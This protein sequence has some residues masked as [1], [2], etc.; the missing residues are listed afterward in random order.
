M[1]NDWQARGVVIIIIAFYAKTRK[2]VLPG[3]P[4]DDIKEA[5]IRFKLKWQTA[6]FPKA[7]I[8]ATCGSQDY[9]KS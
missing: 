3:A 6:A 8:R 2:F 7:R 1:V 9:P 4:V 5:E